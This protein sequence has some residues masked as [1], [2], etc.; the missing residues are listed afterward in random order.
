MIH[1]IMSKTILIILKKLLK[2]WFKISKKDPD[3]HITE[4]ILELIEQDEGEGQHSIDAD[5]RALLGNVLDLKDTT[6]SSIQI[7]R[8]EIVMVPNTAKVEEILDI[9]IEKKMSQLII[10]KSEI[11]N[12][13]GYVTQEEI[14]SCY[15]NPKCK[16]DLKNFLRPLDFI[17]P[18]MQILDCL[19][20]MKEKGQKMAIVIDEY[21]SVDGL[22]TFTDLIEEIIGDIQEGEAI[23]PPGTIAVK[24]NGEV[25]IDGHTRLEIMDDALGTNLKQEPHNEEVHTIAGLI[26]EVI[27]RLP[28][29]GEVILYKDNIE[30]LI[31][32]ATPRKI[33]RICIRNLKINPKKN[34]INF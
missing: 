2:L 19:L 21:G 11:D 18:S 8:S 15:K 27:G 10:Y 3:G 31:L 34:L 1:N 16:F 28:S 4:T 30:F 9:M 6:V 24:E 12:I 29:R 23:N 14:I 26:C 32:D 20:I 5:E 13:L 25:I 7:P 17:A 33:S 22:V